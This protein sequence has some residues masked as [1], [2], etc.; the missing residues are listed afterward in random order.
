MEMWI[1]Y[2]YEDGRLFKELAAQNFT[3][4]CFNSITFPQ[5]PH[6]LLVQFQI[7]KTAMNT[8]TNFFFHLGDF[9]LTL[10]GERGEESKHSH[11]EHKH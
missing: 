5:I 4:L 8:I 3:V 9:F 10:P 6:T 1:T 7:S 2:L 11:V